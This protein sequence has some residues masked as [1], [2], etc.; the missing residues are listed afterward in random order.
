L[1]K[2]IKTKQVEALAKQ[3]STV[4]TKTIVKDV[5][6]KIDEETIINVDETR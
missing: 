2:E 3:E 5:N 4:K 6:V 1:K